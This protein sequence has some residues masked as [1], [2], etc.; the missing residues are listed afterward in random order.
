LQIL[1]TKL[2]YARYPFTAEASA[3]IKSRSINPI[4]LATPEFI[5]ILERA[6]ERVKQG[7]LSGKISAE[8]T[9]EDVD[10]L[11]YPTALMI[12]SSIGD[13]RTR[14]RYALAEAKR[15]SSY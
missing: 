4:E 14:R 10:I 15:A 6:K 11:A 8:L 13:D 1:L 12:I 7:V 5:P 9:Q 2:D 3:Y